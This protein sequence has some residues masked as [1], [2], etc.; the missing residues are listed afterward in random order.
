MRANLGADAV[1]ERRDDLAARRVVL[2]IGGEDDQQVERQPDRVA[3]DLD[4]PLLKD[5][6]QPHLNAAGEVGQLVDREDAA[7]RPRQQPVVH[8]QLVAELEPAPRRLDRIDVADHVGDGHVRR[9]EL[10]DVALVAVTATR[11]ADRRPASRTRAR[12]KAR[13]ARADRR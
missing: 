2:G 8:R 10:F 7:V 11:S 3:L 9:R 5:V 6:E 12:P 13:A 4:V 1:L